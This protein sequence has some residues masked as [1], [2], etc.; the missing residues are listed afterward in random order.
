MNQGNFILR[1]GLFRHATI[2]NRLILLT[3]VITISVGLLVGVLVWLHYSGSY[4]IVGQ[5]IILL[6]AFIIVF[7]AA[8]GIA[9]FISRTISQAI[10]S[11]ESDALKL[12]GGELV[13]PGRTGLAETDTVQH[14]LAS[15]SQELQTREVALRALNT[16]LEQHAADRSRE[17]AQM[18]EELIQAQKM[19]ALGRLTGGIAHDFNNLLTA[20]IGNVELVQRRVADDRSV[21]QLGAARQAAERG[22]KLTSQLLAFSRR[23]NLQVKAT[24]VNAALLNAEELLRST[25]G[26]YV[27][28]EI[29][30]SPD[31]WPAVTDPTQLDLIIMNLVINARDAMTSSGVIT[32]ETKNVIISTP[33]LKREEPGPG[34]YVAVIVSDTGSGMTRDVAS[35]VFEPFFT[36]KGPGLGTGLG[37]SQVL[38]VLKQLE[39]GISLR[40]LPDIGTSVTIFLPRSTVAAGTE[41][42]EDQPASELT[43]C[44]ALIIDDDADVRGVTASLL[45]DLGCS[46]IEAPNG[47]VGLTL[48][49]Q[50]EIDFVLIDYAMPGLNGTETAER[51]LASHPHVPIL[52]MSGYA[53]L[54]TIETGWSG[55]LL[56]KPFTSSALS[57][58][59]ATIMSRGTNGR[60]PVIRRSS[61]E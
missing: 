39:G 11:L 42:A 19:E 43:E 26:A 25:L 44:R 46:V 9:L 16:T 48:L 7:S 50:H 23:Q 56:T 33:P 30:P 21:R 1:P 58:K 34:T 3:T 38:G 59:I 18:T 10:R 4:G 24:D 20:V 52:L 54:E 55:P 6:T 5:R 45:R 22:A 41:I 14:A 13:T 35:R 2:S 61:Y 53:D 31:L 40:T 28:L 17:L 32:I 15:A 51:I 36:T 27:K 49:P 12:A 29:I 57:A 47:A 37:L 60:E 8:T